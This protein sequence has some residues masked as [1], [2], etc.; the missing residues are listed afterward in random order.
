VYANSDF[1]FRRSTQTWAMKTLKPRAMF[2]AVPRVTMLPTKTQPAQ[3][4]HLEMVRRQHEWDM[5]RGLA[6]ATLPATLARKYPT[7]DRQW[8]WQW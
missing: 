5:A 3:R 4:Q 6:R 8:G 7:A 2:S 1:I